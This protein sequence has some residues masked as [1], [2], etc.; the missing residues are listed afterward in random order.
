MHHLP[1]NDGERPVDIVRRLKVSRT[2]VHT[3]KKLYEESGGFS[4]KEKGGSKVDHLP[5][6]LQV[7]CSG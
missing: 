3:D 7:H 6:D 1:P 2:T 5:R 4:K